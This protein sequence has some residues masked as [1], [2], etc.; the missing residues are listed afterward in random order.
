ME[1]SEGRSDLHVIFPPQWSPFQPFLS[2]PALKAYLEQH[3]YRV[4][5]DDWNIAF[6]RWFVGPERLPRARARLRRYAEALTDEDT[7]YRAKCLHAL[8]VLEEHEKLLGL[9]AGLRGGNA[10]GVLSNFKES[11][12]AL[13]SLLDAFS[14][15]EPVIEVGT[16]SMSNGNVL[17]S[18]QSSRSWSSSLITTPI[19][20]SNSSSARLATSPRHRAISA[21]LSS[22]PNRSSPASRLG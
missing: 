22:E 7:I 4:Q 8:A 12:D 3:G 16:T 14:A 5:Q 1:P 6:Y 9:M 20:L 10:C 2:T 17:N 15:A 19:H 18:T 21:S 13:T 11:V